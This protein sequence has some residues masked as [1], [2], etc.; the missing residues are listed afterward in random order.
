MNDG[1]MTALVSEVKKAMN[2]TKV[3]QSLSSSYDNYVFL[4]MDNKD[5]SFG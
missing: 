4:D 1:N 5:E 3:S 2:A